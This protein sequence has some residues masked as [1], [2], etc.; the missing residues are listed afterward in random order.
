MTGFRPF[1]AVGCILLL[2][3][4]AWAAQDV[5]AVKATIASMPLGASIEV[6]LK[7]HQ[8]LRGGRGAVSD[9][10]FSLIDTRSGERQVSF[11]EVASVKSFHPKSH[12]GR[13]ILI[14]VG[15]GVGAVA[16]LIVA[17]AHSGGYL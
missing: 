4:P 8:K 12:T 1:L 9:A 3:H 11:D 7:D 15:I 13:N 16:I 5:T 10:G 6:R 17:L 2:T 14:G